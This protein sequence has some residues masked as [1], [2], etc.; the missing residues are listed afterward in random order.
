MRGRMDGPVVSQR[1]DGGREKRGKS[2]DE[3]VDGTLTH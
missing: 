3:W 2:A 1:G